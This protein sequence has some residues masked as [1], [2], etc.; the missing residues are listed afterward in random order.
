MYYRFSSL[1]YKCGIPILPVRKLA[2]DCC[3]YGN[4]YQS[5]GFPLA[6]ASL[7]FGEIHLLMQKEMETLLRVLGGQVNL[8]L[9]I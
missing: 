8:L 3:K 5:Y 1:I 6:R 7:E 4:E 2:E 9:A